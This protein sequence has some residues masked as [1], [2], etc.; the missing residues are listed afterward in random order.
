MTAWWTGILAL[1]GVILF[2]KGF[3][4]PPQLVQG[5]NN[6]LPEWE[7]GN[8]SAKFDRAV[9]MVIDAWR[10]DFAYDSE[11]SHFSYL[12]SL[13][14]SGNAIPYT[15]FAPSPTVTLPRLKGITS[16]SAPNFL[17]AVLNI[18]DDIISEGDPDDMS[19][20]NGPSLP[21]SWIA[22]AHRAGKALRLFGD[23]TWLRLFPTHVFDSVSDGTKS[24][25]VTDF[26]EVDQNV[27][28]HLDTQLYNHGGD[29]A[30][31][32]LILHYLGLDHIGHQGGA[33]SV[34]MPEKHH[35]MD[36]VI[37]RVYE[38]LDEKT[39]FIV[40]GDHGMTES[41][42]HGGSSEPETSPAL[43]FLG[44]SLDA[45]VGNHLEYTAPVASN[46]DSDYTYNF[47][48][49]VQQVDLVPTL[50]VLLG[51]P[52]ARNSLGVFLPEFL[53]LY[54]SDADK[55]AI[56]HANLRQLGFT[57][58]L[59]ISIEAAFEALY[60]LQQSKLVTM[61]NYDMQ[62]VYAGVGLVL[63]AFLWSTWSLVQ[64][65]IT[66]LYS[67][68]FRRKQISKFNM[69]FIPTSFKS[70]FCVLFFGGV[71]IGIMSASSFV[72]EEHYFWLWGF[73]GGL[74]LLCIVRSYNGW[75]AMYMQTAFVLAVLRVIRSWHAMGQKWA[76]LESISSKF[77]TSLDSN[78]SGQIWGLGLWWI[79]I[80]YYMSLILRSTS[81]TPDLLLFI[82]KC[83]AI[84]ASFVFKLTTAMNSGEYVPQLFAH[85]N[86]F[87]HSNPIDLART[88]YLA[89]F[90]SMTYITLDVI[91]ESRNT[92][93]GGSLWSKFNRVLRKR[94]FAHNEGPYSVLFELFLITQSRV[95]NI[96]LFALFALM[97]APLLS[98][99]A[100]NSPVINGMLSTGIQ[101]IAFFCLGNSNSL[102]SI[103][104]SN[105]YNGV[106][107]YNIPIVSAFTFINNWAGPFYW[108][109]AFS[110]TSLSS[111]AHQM[112]TKSHLP[113]STFYTS[114]TTIHLLYLAETFGI[115]VSTMLLRHHL[116]I[117]TVF[118]PKILY[119]CA[120]LLFHLV[121]SLLF[122]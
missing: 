101:H 14:N 56:A 23:D 116:F 20:G 32:I 105:A 29:D 39:L 113:Y 63:F 41:G 103:D 62:S 69:W 22:Q 10:A 59:P 61:S 77:M 38:S 67:P 118:S 19:S 102:A 115:F 47:Y 108:A 17:D 83:S 6:D 45:S 51:L 35:E 82:L 114:L 98:L 60:S 76:D 117:W 9:I 94:Y 53:A 7:S 81:T 93:G 106:S 36:S 107:T 90:L 3:F 43:L 89:I 110:T 75:P 30:W 71:Y 58:S 11:R 5:F 18:A 119:T 64:L 109:N 28:R 50:S 42:N 87:A 40:L 54:P 57:G 25:Y 13:I 111:T 2:C 21:D 44:K 34:H 120:W 15:A 97:K 1:I 78:E 4:T 46:S 112:A 100:Y 80:V 55:L 73:S 121:S 104:L 48:K 27:T 65:D 33:S 85:L 88:A 95:V 12:H 52:I 8:E 74:A 24:F 122:S 68:S 66:S 79:I 91:S 37:Q 99:C 84:V 92:S 16:G 31:D 86:V 49:K 96:P 70:K 72:E 26:V